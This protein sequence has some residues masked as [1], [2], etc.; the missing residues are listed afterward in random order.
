MPTIYRCYIKIYLIHRKI[1]NFKMSTDQIRSLPNI[2]LLL[3][4]IEPFLR[5]VSHLFDREIE[6]ERVDGYTHFTGVALKDGR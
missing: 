4:V 2:D 1:R 3:D 5:F 6:L